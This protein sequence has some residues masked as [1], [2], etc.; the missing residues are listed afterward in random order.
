M[1]KY[2]FI[3]WI[4]AQSAWVGAQPAY[5]PGTFKLTPKREATLQPVSVQ[6]PPEFDHLPRDLTLNL[7]PGFSA[8]VFSAHDFNRP[9]LLA[10]DARGVLHVADMNNKR[11]VALPDADGNG[12]ADEAITIADG[13]RRAH[14]LAFLGDAMF[15][16]D[17]HQIVRYRDVDG[18]GTYRQREVFA[19]NIPS[20]GSHSTRTIV[21]DEKNGK[22]YLSVGWPCD[23]CR[24]DEPER[25]VIL[26]IQYGRHGSP[27][28]CP[29]RAQRGGY[30]FTPGNQSA[31]GH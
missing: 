6:I 11:I 9:R 31:V 7:P 10:F 16:G 14:S 1:Q 22:V 23:M 20:S 17:R 26:R 12:V 19:D 28:L 18:D 25:G 2:I 3:A 15:V 24:L 29:R 8:S 4:V 21:L 13:F 30:G 27:R 5:G